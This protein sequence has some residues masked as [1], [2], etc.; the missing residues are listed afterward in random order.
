MTAVNVRIT[1]DRVS[2]A[3]TPLS[4]R[5]NTS[6]KP[7]HILTPTEQVAQNTAFTTIKWETSLTDCGLVG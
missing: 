5:T 1:E 7:L 3:S 2:V 6:M 4:W